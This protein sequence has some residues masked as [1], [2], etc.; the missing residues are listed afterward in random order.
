M[1]NIIQNSAIILAKVIHSQTSA[2]SSNME[3][4]LQNVCIKETDRYR[5]IKPLMGP[6][7]SL[8]CLTQPTSATLG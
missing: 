2:R 3:I 4:F 8:S 7:H 5:N 1:T 6:V